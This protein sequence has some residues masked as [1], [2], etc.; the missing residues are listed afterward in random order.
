MTDRMMSF[1]R[2]IALALALAST[3]AWSPH[4]SE[5][6]RDQ[7]EARE[8]RPQPQ[9]LTEATD[10][11]PGV[12]TSRQADLLPTKNT[13][14]D[15]QVGWGDR[16]VR[17]KVQHKNRMELPKKRVPS[18]SRRK[19]SYDAWSTQITFTHPYPGINVWRPS[20]YPLTRPYY[21]PIFGAPGRIPI[22]YPPQAIVLN[23]GTPKDNPTKKPFKGPLYLPPVEPTTSS[24]TTMKISNR[25]DD[26]PIWDL[27]DGDQ[28][29]TQRPVPTTTSIVPTR[30]TRP[31][32]PRPPLIHKPTDPEGV[33]VGEFTDAGLGAP[34]SN[35]V[36]RPAPSTAAPPRQADRPRELSR[37][38][39]A[40]ISCCTAMADISYECFEQRG[41]PGAFWDN[42]PCDNEFAQA[43]IASALNYYNDK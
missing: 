31:S 9:L 26:R 38:T 16:F 33:A 17:E 12:H 10:H 4:P 41:C 20:L 34:V 36:N 25:F 1:I 37:C 21:V 2:V 6:A 19:R 11:R 40:I 30:R 14:R 28:S 23:P 35:Q 7:Y 5:S 8:D 39:W 3:T 18:G 24:S 13:V 27:G 15:L 32:R 43:A 29:P 22:F 42:N